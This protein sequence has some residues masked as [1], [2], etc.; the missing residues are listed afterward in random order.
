LNGSGYVL[1][2]IWSARK[3]LEEKS[4]E[5]VLHAAISLGN[6]TDTTA[7]VA[8]GLAG[9]RHGPGGIPQDWLNQLLGFETVAP[10]ILDVFTK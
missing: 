9:I 1:D 8:G 10:L 4:F 7:A 2:T 6:D 3:A 5:A